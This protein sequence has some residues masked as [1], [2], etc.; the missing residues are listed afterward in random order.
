MG[1]DLDNILKPILDALSHLIYVDDQQIER[2]LAQKFE[3][4]RPHF[5]ENPSGHLA[6]AMERSR[7]VL[8][9]RVDNDLSRGG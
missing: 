2:I 6:D 1:A 3:P 5:I 9:I 7:P 4:G 8:Y